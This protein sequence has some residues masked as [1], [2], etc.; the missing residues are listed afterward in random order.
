MLGFII[1]RAFDLSS[2]S[3]IMLS[4]LKIIEGIIPADIFGFTKSRLSPVCRVILRSTKFSN[5]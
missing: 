5:F 4:A 1:S 2:L 3:T